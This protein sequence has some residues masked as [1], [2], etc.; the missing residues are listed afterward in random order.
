MKK[1]E[2]KDISN[3]FLIKVIICVLVFWV[4][5]L[6]MIFV[7]F[8]AMTLEILCYIGFGIIGVIYLTVM[9]IALLAKILKWKL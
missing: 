6:T 3:K 4:F 8:N 5:A 7:G 1:R 9:T 2:E